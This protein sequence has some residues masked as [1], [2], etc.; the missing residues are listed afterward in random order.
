MPRQSAAAKQ[1]EQSQ[2]KANA[3]AEAFNKHQRCETAKQ[4]V[5]VYRT[6]RPVYTLDN[7]ADRHYV[8]D[9]ERAAKLAT[10]QRAM[11]ES[12]N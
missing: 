9:A 8:E 12:C 3:E 10:W 2:S 5:D 4:Q 7:K 1:I 6:A 11:A